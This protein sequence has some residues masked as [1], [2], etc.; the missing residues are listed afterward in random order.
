M[1]CRLTS[2]LQL[3]QIQL[4]KN[5]HAAQAKEKCDKRQS[6]SYVF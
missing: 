2:D 1:P 3:K 4:C 5:L 6:D